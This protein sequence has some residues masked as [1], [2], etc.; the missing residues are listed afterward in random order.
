MPNIRTTM[1]ADDVAKQHFTF[2]QWNILFG[3]VI[4]IGKK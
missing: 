2:S 4:N 3:G 1:S